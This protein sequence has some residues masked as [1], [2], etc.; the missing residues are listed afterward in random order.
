[1]MTAP[2]HVGIIMD[3]N[4]RWAKE[5]DVSILEGHRAGYRALKALL[6]A[7]KRSNIKYLSVYAFSVENWSRSMPEVKGLMSLLKWVF[8][9]ELH[10]FM[11]EDIRIRV[12]GSRQNLSNDIRRLI[13][14]A[15]QETAR[16]KSGV[17]AVCF[18]YGGQ[19]EIADAARG[20]VEKGV[21]AQDITDK[22]IAGHLYASDIPPLD[23]IIRTSGEQRL[24]NFMLWR[25]AYAELYFVDKH[26]PDF[27]PAD[28]EA[29][30]AEFAARQRRY[31][32]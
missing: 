32:A 25:A 14:K 23:L 26:W 4:R 29:A 6:P 27:T 18:N 2:R 28:F 21:K 20:I 8:K 19:Q 5:H 12:I 10:V 7:F 1:M 11:E 15:Q 16:N 9:N 3:G 30:L 24:S 13:D 31:G 17:L 22:L